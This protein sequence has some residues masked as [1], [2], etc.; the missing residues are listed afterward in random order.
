MSIHHTF[1][2]EQQDHHKRID[3]FLQQHLPNLSRT[4]IARLIKEGSACIN[5]NITTKPGHLVAA[6]QTVTIT[7]IPKSAF[8]LT[9][10][11]AQ[12]IEVPIIAQTNDFIV[13]NKPAG[14]ITHPTN[15]TKQQVSVSG[16]A[17]ALFPEIAKVGD[18]QRP[19][20]VHRLDA[21]TSGLMVIAR[22]LQAY[23]TLKTMFKDR[24][25]TKEYVALVAGH[26][27][28]TGTITMPLGRHPL[29]RTTVIVKKDGRPAITNYYV[30]EYFADSARV[31]IHLVTG[32][33]HQIRVHFQA[34]KHPL[35]GDHIYGKRTPL[36]KRQALHA[37][38][39]SFDYKGIHYAFAAPLP[40]DMDTLISNL[41]AKNR[42][43][44]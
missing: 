33:T 35:L 8:T 4:T 26:P 29:K 10:T 19:G 37:Q 15:S 43:A 18:P 1:S 5:N 12:K 16:W 32:R 24:S 42:V 41:R 22:T 27:E 11:D 2:V 44:F 6:G 23:E 3:H 21:A 9:H 17:Q 20:I 38:K 28:Q 39:L 34:I 14:L 31:N 25:I 36:I 7:I 30:Q 13:I 40:H